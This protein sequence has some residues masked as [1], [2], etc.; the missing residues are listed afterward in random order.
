MTSSD[1][2]KSEIDF[3]QYFEYIY[4]EEPY[5]LKFEVNT[6]LISIYIY[7]NLQVPDLLDFLKEIEDMYK[8]YALEELGWRRFGVRLHDPTDQ[9]AKKYSFGLCFESVNQNYVDLEQ[10]CNDFSTYLK[11]QKH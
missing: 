9:I 4:S 10:S 2:F 7:H 11:L 1:K 5:F 8:L 3:C 6:A